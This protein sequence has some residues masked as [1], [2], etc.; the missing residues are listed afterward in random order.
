M[1]IDWDR[2]VARVASLATDDVRRLCCVARYACSS[3][4]LSVKRLGN[5]FGYVDHGAP[6]QERG[7]EPPFA[8]HALQYVNAA[9]RKA[10]PGAGHQIFDRTGKRPPLGGLPAPPHAYRCG[11]LCRSPCC[12]SPHIHPYAARRYERS[13]H[14]PCP[15]I[16]TASGASILALHSLV[17]HTV[18]PTG[19]MW[20]FVALPLPGQPKATRMRLPLQGTR[21]LRGSLNGCGRLFRRAQPGA[22]HSGWARSIPRV[23][24]RY[25]LAK[26][27]ERAKAWS[28]GWSYTKPAAS[29]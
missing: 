14:Q 26:H 22:R 21:R 12:P 7:E 18:T 2:L 1:G 16:G 29:H 23:R 4:A 28:R 19:F 10:Q 3:D 9:I 27:C 24:S 17:S 6:L 11:R 8:G 25:A 13:M 15:T 20:V 5:G